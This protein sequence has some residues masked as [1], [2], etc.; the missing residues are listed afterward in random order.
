MLEVYKNKYENNLFKLTSDGKTFTISQDENANVYWN[1]YYDAKETDNSDKITFE[2]T[3][4]NYYIYRVFDELYHNIKS[5]KESK[6]Y[7]KII[8]GKDIIWYSDDT[9]FNQVSISPSNDKYILV[10][11]NNG[12]ALFTGNHY[13]KFKNFGN[14]NTP[15]NLPFL[16]MY[17]KLSNGEYDLNQICIEEVLYKLNNPKKLSRVRR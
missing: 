13:I 15:F 9:S 17:D 16:Q 11:T 4:E 3:K 10:F 1:C 2:I 6:E 14:N 8:N 5:C 7:S 12:E